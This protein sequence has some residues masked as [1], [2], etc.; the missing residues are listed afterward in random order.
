MIS[1][2]ELI[3]RITMD[4]ERCRM[5]GMDN[6]DITI[7]MSRGCYKIICME[8]YGLWVSPDGMTLCGF[9]VVETEDNDV[10]WYISTVHGKVE[11]KE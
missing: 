10:S 3:A 5:H 7:L 4:C 8:F 6:R 11:D 9:P 1:A 2:H